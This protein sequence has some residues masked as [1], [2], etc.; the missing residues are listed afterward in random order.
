MLL[1]QKSPNH[2][3][4]GKEG[5]DVVHWKVLNWGVVVIFIIMRVFSVKYEGV[6][7][8][9]AEGRNFLGGYG[10]MLERDCLDHNRVVEIRGQISRNWSLIV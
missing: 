9:M 10:S 5:N 2:E 6:Q 8:G 7:G 3:T 4:K 1:W